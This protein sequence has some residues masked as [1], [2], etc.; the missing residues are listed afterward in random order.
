M[1]QSLKNA[2]KGD[3][4][5]LAERLRICFITSNNSS[6]LEDIASRLLEFDRHCE[7]WGPL[8]CQTELQLKQFRL[9][10]DRVDLVL[11][12]G[13]TGHVGIYDPQDPWNHLNL[14]TNNLPNT[15]QEIRKTFF[16]ILARGLV[17][18]SDQELYF[19]KLIAHFE[20]SRLAP[21]KL[22]ELRYWEATST[23][24]QAFGILNM[25][26]DDDTLDFHAISEHQKK[27]R[28]LI[29]LE[30][31]S[32][33]ERLRDIKARREWKELGERAISYINGWD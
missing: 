32:A 5:T 21:N 13:F 19:S 7:S 29:E 33:V 1:A 20:D 31:L 14:P 25:H 11:L 9:D 4:D 10:A 23:A 3:V 8:N 24:S 6:E 28:V 2:L 15:L 17:T 18:P 22:I 16:S 30:G 12:N 26:T 27:M